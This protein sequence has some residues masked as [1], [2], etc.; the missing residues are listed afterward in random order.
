MTITYKNYEIEVTE[1]SFELYQTRPPKQN[2][3]A[4]SSEVRCNLGYFSKL[5]QAISKIIMVDLS[6]RH[7]KVTLSNFMELYRRLSKEVESAIQ[8]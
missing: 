6:N 2:D 3:K 4:I 7:E 8:L 5:P 1:S